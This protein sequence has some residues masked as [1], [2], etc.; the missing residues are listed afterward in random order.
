MSLLRPSKKFMGRP[1]ENGLFHVKRFVPPKEPDEYVD[2]LE[3]QCSHFESGQ[4][5]VLLDAGQALCSEPQSLK[6]YN[7]L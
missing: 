4:R 1:N 3:R 5:E 6:K 7:T 2:G